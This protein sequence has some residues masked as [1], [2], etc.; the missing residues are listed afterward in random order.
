VSN[1]VL[2]YMWM[3]NCKECGRKRSWLNLR[4]YPG[5]F[6]WYY[7][8]ISTDLMCFTEANLL[9]QKT[10]TLQMSSTYT[11][12]YQANRGRDNTGCSKSHATHGLLRILCFLDVSFKEI[13]ASTISGLKPSRLIFMGTSQWHCVFK[14][15]THPARASGQH[16]AHCGQ[17]INWHIAK[18][19][20]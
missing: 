10:L 13:V 6:Y 18:R 7:P 16:S 12:I 17:D 8:G 20:R 9:S 4:Y 11:R 2:S 15:S 5:I 14:K 1:E 19:V 3:M